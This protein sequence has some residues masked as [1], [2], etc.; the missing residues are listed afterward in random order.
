MRELVTGPNRRDAEAF[1]E[2]VDRRHDVSRPA[3]VERG[4]TL[5]DRFD[6]DDR[7]IVEIALARL[8][9]LEG[10]S[11]QSIDRLRRART[12]P[13][14]DVQAEATLRLVLVLAASGRTDEALTE[15]DAARDW[16]PR[17]KLP[18]LLSQIGFVHNMMSQFSLAISNYDEAVKLVREAADDEA[19][20]V[21]LN[22]RG[23]T[24]TT[25]GNFD[26]A[27]ID[28]REAMSLPDVGAHDTHSVKFNLGVVLGRQGLLRASLLMLDE[29]AKGRTSSFIAGM[30][31]LD[32]AEVLF[33]ARALP[34][35]AEV[36]ER[37]IADLEA[38]ESHAILARLQVMRARVAI[39]MGEPEPGRWLRRAGNTLTSQGRV[40][41]A[42]NVEI[43]V[44]TLDPDRSNVVVPIDGQ[45]DSL[46]IEALV[47]RGHE[48][49]TL[50]RRDDAHDTFERVASM[51]AAA[52]ADTRI[53]QLY[54]SVR[55]AQLADQP[56]RAQAR[57]D[58]CFD[59]LERHAG[60]LESF[61]LRSR[62]L[63][64]IAPLEE[65]A[66]ELSDTRS[67]PGDLIH[68]IDRIRRVVLGGPSMAIPSPALIDELERLRRTIDDKGNDAAGRQRAAIEARIRF[69]SWTTERAEGARASGVSLADLTHPGMLVFAERN[70]RLVG[71]CVGRS[72]S[73]VDLGPIAEISKLLAKIRFQAS[74]AAAKGTTRDFDAIG[75]TAAQ[76]D[77]IIIQPLIGDQRFDRVS[78]VPAGSIQS[79]PW[80]LL[81]S[82]A[83]V[84]ARVVAGHYPTVTSPQTIEDEA[85][86]RLV[87][88]SGP[89][90]NADTELSA[91]RALYES[92]RALE[93]NDATCRNVLDAFEHSDILHIAAHGSIR[94]D[95]PL[96]SNLDL[97]DGP[98][99][100][101]DIETAERVPDV[102]VLACCRLGGSAS[103]HTA[104]Y[105]LASVLSARGAKAIVASTVDLSDTH[106]GIV[107][108]DL[109]R[110]LRDGARADQALVSLRYDEP[111]LD[112]EA[113]SLV[114]IC[115]I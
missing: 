74:I 45:T 67:S 6:G 42:A 50:Q 104:G 62:A 3:L 91:V 15:G 107:M 82:V 51:P 58:A 98:L 90:L 13:G 33:V 7:A 99:T 57:L 106:S 112:L 11:D 38:T 97:T 12:A 59:R 65:L 54:A 101:Y 25:I 95:D 19:L 77:R 48:Q 93:A 53:L 22:N 14:R 72:E 64:D 24:H 44:D 113:R 110:H 27:E 114:A 103:G 43:V 89:G 80:R 63:A 46:M 86:R 88:V 31:A 83:T 47:D 92:S 37:A 105:G 40:D 111:T 26:Q 81:P 39:A 28:L 29:A 55:A 1:L 85:R 34:D 17:S 73:I 96:L 75:R 2:A 94:N 16:V 109:H 108:S 115:A 49:L 87:A 4:H 68:W 79:V 10:R 20:G 30:D 23:E 21:I 70:D 5:L 69:L 76:L 60:G 66:V 84:P 61:E 18:R 52:S 102:V 8:D 100:A 36:L 78:I 56:D 9:R 32:R 71:V 41:E 35:S